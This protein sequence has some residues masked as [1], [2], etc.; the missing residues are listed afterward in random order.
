MACIV[1]SFL[2]CVFPAFCHA[3]SKVRFAIDLE[4]NGVPT[5]YVARISPEAREMFTASNA[6]CTLGA[7]NMIH[8]S[9]TTSQT[10][11]SITQVYVHI[12]RTESE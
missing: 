10:L 7:W 5:L 1:S 11:V 3:C 4:W 2:H 12:V 8:V 9:L 6:V